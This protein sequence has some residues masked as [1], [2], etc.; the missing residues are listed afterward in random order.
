MAVPSVRDADNL[1]H[2]LQT[3]GYRTG[4]VGPHI[5]FDG[6]PPYAD[7]YEPAEI[8]LGPPGPPTCPDNLYGEYVRFTLI[9][10]TWS[11]ARRSRVDPS[12]GWA[13]DGELLVN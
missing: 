6:P 3:A 10:R 13:L 4:F 8:P 5:P 11:P 12:P 9:P 7:L 1:L 2:R